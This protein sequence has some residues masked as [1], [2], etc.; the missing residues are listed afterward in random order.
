MPDRL[1]LRG[2]AML[3]TA[4]WTVA[5]D[6]AGRGP[7]GP[8]LRGGLVGHT[9]HVGGHADHMGIFFPVEPAQQFMDQLAG[10]PGP[11][12]AYL[13]TPTGGLVVGGPEHMI[14]GH[15]VGPATHPVTHV[16]ARGERGEDVI[17]QSAVVNAADTDHAGTATAQPTPPT[18]SPLPPRPPGAAGPGRPD[19]GRWGPGRPGPGQ[20]PS[21]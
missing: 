18:A 15:L 10:E 19:I 2:I 6:A 16:A 20:P 3:S 1:I 13:G 11:A 4:V 9:R 14:A 17:P 21:P 8:P 7:H 12:P 5:A